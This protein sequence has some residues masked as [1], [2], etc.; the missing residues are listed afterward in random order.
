M[1]RSQKFTK[2]S[3]EHNVLHKKKTI[4]SVSIIIYLVLAKFKTVIVNMSYFKA[5]KF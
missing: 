3:Y 1:S 2:I 5:I 4:I